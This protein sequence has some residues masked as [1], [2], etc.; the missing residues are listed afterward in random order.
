MM[1]ERSLKRCWR[2]KMIREEFQFT[3]VKKMDEFIC[4][5]LTDYNPA[6][7]GTM[8]SIDVEFNYEEFMKT[9]TVRYNVLMSRLE[10]CD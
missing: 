2:K 9:H 7:Y 10:S 4:K 1:M 5:Y 8:F 3:D 6:G